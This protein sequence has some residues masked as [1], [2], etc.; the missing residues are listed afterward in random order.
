MRFDHE[1]LTVYGTALQFLIL[2]AGLAEEW[3]PSGCA[4]LGDQLR[5]AAASILFNIAEGAGEFR[6]EEKARFYRMTRRSAT[7]CASILDAFRMWPRPSEETRDAEAREQSLAQ[8]RQQ[9]IEVVSMLTTMAR[10][11]DDSA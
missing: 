8:G 1:R 10:R 4:F 2:A 11:F 5:R 7:E 6:P 9:L 3:T